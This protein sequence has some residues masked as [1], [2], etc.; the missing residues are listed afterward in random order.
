MPGKAKK[1]KASVVAKAPEVAKPAPAVSQVLPA[2]EAALF[3]QIIKHYETKQYKK[4]VK[5]ADGILA[6]FPLHGE[7]LAMKGLTYNCLGKKE[8][9]MQLVKKG[10]GQNLKSH[11]CWHVYGLLYR[12]DEKY[13]DAIKCYQNAIRLDPENSQVL[14]DLSL[15]Q[16]QQRDTEGF[17]ETR[18]KI[19]VTKQSNRNNWIAYAVGKHLCGHHAK[20]VEIIDSYDQTADEYEKVGYEY[21]EML[22]YKNMV[23]EE[24]GNIEE[25][26]KHLDEV[27]SQ[28]VDKLYVLERRAEMM[29]QLGKK[30]EAEVVFRKLLTINPENYNYHHGLA[31]SLDI[32]DE[33]SLTTLYAGLAVEFPKIDAIERLPLD[34]STGAAFE[35]LVGKYIQARM[36]RGIPSLFRDLRDLH[37]DPKKLELLRTL[38]TGYVASLESD[39]R[40][41]AEQ[42]KNA[43]APSALVWA[44]YFQAQQLDMFGDQV[45][46]LATVERL[47]RHTPT[48]VDSYVLKARILKH[49]GDL[50]SAHTWMDQARRMDTADRYLNTKCTRYALR[51]LDVPKA[52]ETVT[53]F[54]R[55]GDTLISLY[56]MQCSWYENSCGDTHVELG[57]AARALKQYTSVIKHFHDFEEDQFDF[58]SYCLRKMTL[59]S[60]VKM[61]RMEDE[62]RGHRFFVRASRGTVSTYLTLYDRK[63]KI[64]KALAAAAAATA[65]LDPAEQKRLEKK[66]KRDAAKLEADLK[67]EKEESSKKTKE[68]DKK[69]VKVGRSGKADEDPYGEQLAAVEDPLK[70]AAKYLKDLLFYD[71]NSIESHLLACDVY[72]RSGKYLLWLRSLLR[73]K[74]LGAEAAV[75][76]GR[77]AG[78]LAALAAEKAVHPM[79]QTVVDAE[80]PT[81]CGAHK[82]AKAL[83]SA[84]AASATTLRAQ[85]ELARA[86][87]ACGDAGVVKAL[88][89]CT[90]PGSLKDARL[91]LAFLQEDAAEHVDAFREVCAGRFT[92]CPDFRDEAARI[93]LKKAQTFSDPLTTYITNPKSNHN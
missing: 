82:T 4:G 91:A 11:V 45:T 49:A 68:E 77:T 46:A 88:A 52:E 73:V 56:D 71:N 92:L 74:A 19:L 66:A 1:G 37:K 39:G 38:I 65:G 25:A 14:K 15:L 18:R 90:L 93:E 61:M 3:K 85:L 89:G 33:A 57:D 16:I 81:L 12:S 48:H 36:R 40:F 75:V 7:T 76:A 67:T 62:L 51:A 9:A 83:L 69:E 30:A 87:V 35:A 78:F 21:S 26:A 34:F 47:L 23:L 63:H 55:D 64:T 79:V 20:A 72:D 53:L 6:K 8:E 70:E 59:R 31:K 2:K 10:V 5:V 22:L 27:E 28:V 80:L 13:D 60:Y 24:S 44:L 86:A 54:L 42:E 58:H 32:A 17:T 84:S 41:T 50:P 29:I 43:E